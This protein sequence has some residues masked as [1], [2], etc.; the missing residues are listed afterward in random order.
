MTQG[1]LWMG[2]RTWGG[3]VAPVDPPIVAHGRRGIDNQDT[4]GPQ[5][6][7]RD[8]LDLPPPP[9]DSHCALFPFNRVMC[10]WLENQDSA[11]PLVSFHDPS[12]QL[13]TLLRAKIRPGARVSL[14]LGAGS[15]A[16]RVVVGETPLFSS[17]PDGIDPFLDSY[18][19]GSLGLQL[20]L[21]PTPA[22]PGPGR[23]WRRR[24]L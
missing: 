15:F 22:C 14:D 21:G 17:R 19:G 13:T 24:I 5:W 8:Q 2:S 9:S 20:S 7:T 16:E 23:D 18:Q 6:F 1:Q 3:V 4:I 11:I 12:R 10:S